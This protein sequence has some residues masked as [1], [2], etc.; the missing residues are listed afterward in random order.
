MHQP[1]FSMHKQHLSFNGLCHD[2][3][4]VSCQFC[5][6]AITQC[7]VSKDLLYGVLHDTRATFAPARVHSG[8]LSWLYICVHNSIT[9]CHAIASHPEVSSFRLLYWSGVKNFTMASCKREMTTCF[10]V[11]SVCKLTGMGSTC[12]MFLN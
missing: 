3:A 10:G 8:S 6:E 7:L 9:K 12:I 11:K 2:I 4:A 1:H 5:V